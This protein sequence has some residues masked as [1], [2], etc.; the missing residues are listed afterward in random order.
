MGLPKYQ[1]FPVNP[2]ILLYGVCRRLLVH[3]QEY[4]ASH[5]NPA[6]CF[7]CPGFRGFL[8]ATV[9][10][11]TSHRTQ[12]HHNSPRSIPCPKHRCQFILLF[13]VICGIIISK[14]KGNILL[15]FFIAPPHAGLFYL[16]KGI[17][18]ENTRIFASAVNVARIYG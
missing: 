17:I 3:R 1:K 7:F 15:P 13:I 18:N 2:C 4:R 10:V 5:G 8:L 9:S 16:P 12:S 11:Y 6:G 14:N